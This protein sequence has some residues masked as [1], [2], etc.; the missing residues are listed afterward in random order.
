MPDMDGIQVLREIKRRRLRPK[1]IMVSSLTSEGAQVTT[2]AL[3]EGAFD[4]ILKP[5]G[6]DSEANRR[7][8]RES[9]KEKISAFREASGRRGGR[10]RRRR[11]TRR[12]DQGRGEG[13]A[14]SEPP[15]PGW[16]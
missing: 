3:M 6:T 15:L 16:S 14:H 4:F 13:G 2:D 7:Q 1:A 5:S 12:G 9:L 10:T 8:L 11:P